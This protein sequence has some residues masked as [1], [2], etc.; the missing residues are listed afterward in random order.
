[1]NLSMY[2]RSILSDPKSVSITALSQQLALR[3]INAIKPFIFIDLTKIIR[4]ILAASI[5]MEDRL[6]RFGPWPETGHLQRIDYQ[7]AV[8][9]VFIDPPMM[10]RL[11]KSITTARY[12]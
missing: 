2:N 6:T 11:N 8:D 5:A 12:N 7:T 3:L 10:R 4:G 9:L 1:M